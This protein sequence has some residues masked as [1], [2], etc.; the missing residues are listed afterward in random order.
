V[1][2]SFSSTLPFVFDLLLTHLPSLSDQSQM[3]HMLLTQGLMCAISA[4]MLIYAATVE[5]IAGDFV[6]GNLGG[7]GHAGGHGHSH[8]EE[9]FEEGESGHEHEHEHERVTP[10]KRAIA[11][12]SMLAGVVAMGLIGLGE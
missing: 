8:G 11:V 12:G 4:G 3:A 6:F 1:S 7:G 2:C 9:L 5:M 10:R